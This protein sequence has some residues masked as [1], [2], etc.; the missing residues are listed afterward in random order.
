MY[1]NPC[2]ID[3]S[4]DNPLFIPTIEMHVNEELCLES[5]YDNALDDG[6]MLF[7][8]S[9]VRGCCFCINFIVSFSF[10]FLCQ[11]IASNA[12]KVRGVD[13]LSRNRFCA[14]VA[15]NL[16]TSQNVILF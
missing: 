15:K 16:E 11:E 9:W 4:Y 3:K 14:P 13:L 10:L 1:D 12:S 5:I 7:L 2:Y 6:P 8:I